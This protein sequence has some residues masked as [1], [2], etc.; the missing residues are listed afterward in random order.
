MDGLLNWKRRLR[1]KHLFL[2]K[3][4]GKALFIIISIIIYYSY[5]Q[6]INNHLF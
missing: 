4:F 6:Q 3:I 5:F 1:R 2:K